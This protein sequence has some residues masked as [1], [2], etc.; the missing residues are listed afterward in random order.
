[1]NSKGEGG[2]TDPEEA[3]SS[4]KRKAQVEKSDSSSSGSDQPQSKRIRRGQISDDAA[5][6]SDL[7]CP[8]YA[9]NMPIADVPL[10]IPPN[11]SRMIT[12]EDR[13]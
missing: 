2:G 1:M 10:E 7:N 4:S 13:F 9:P 6:A 5:T 3:R 11:K 12:K 8:A